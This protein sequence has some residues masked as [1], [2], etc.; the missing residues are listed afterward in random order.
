MHIRMAAICA[1]VSC[2]LPAHA[3]TVTEQ[4]GLPAA[5]AAPMLGLAE[6]LTLAQATAPARDAADASIRAAEASQAEAGLR[7]NPRGFAEAENF[8]GSGPYSGFGGTEVTVGVELPVERG[9]K[10]QARIAVAAAQRGGSLV[11]QALALAEVR[12]AATLAFIEAIAA[13]RRL[14]NA[15]RQVELARESY[16]VANARVRAGRA[17]PLE[18][19]RAELEQINAVTEAEAAARLAANA[20]ADLTRMIGQTVTQPLDDAWFSAIGTYG[21]AEPVIPEATLIFSQAEAGVAVADAQV[22][23]A[24]A[25]RTS[26]FTVS[27]GVRGLAETGDVAA[28]VGFSVPLLLFDNGSAAQSRALA[29]RDRALALRRAAILEVEA[30]LADAQTELAN[31]TARARTSSG[32]AL[33]A[34]EEAARI[35]R[36]GYREGRLGQLDLLE[37]ERMLAETNSRM[38]EALAAYHA[39]EARLARLTAPLPQGAN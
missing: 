19:Q 39:A 38:V 31:A 35:S 10:R 34:A 5:R 7:P 12:Q 1:A 20:R 6:V 17:S 22:S 25:Q 26:D 2:A 37:A 30:E 27:A 15:Q 21:P 24:A 28:V 3:Q 8:I 18:E 13:D 33:A 32:P 29:E 36:I 16:R 4:P 23:L 9:G 14:S 11:D